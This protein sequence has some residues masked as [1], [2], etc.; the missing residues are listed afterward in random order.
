MRPFCG[1]TTW[2]AA[3]RKSLGLPAFD[4]WEDYRVDRMLANMAATG[5]ISST[6]ARR[7]MIERNG[8]AFE[9]AQRRAAIEYGVSAMGST[10]AIPA[11]AYPPGEERMRELAVEYQG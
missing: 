4:Q 10:L 2:R 1:R 8:E 9:E 7:A 11:A 5:D 3:I 6:E